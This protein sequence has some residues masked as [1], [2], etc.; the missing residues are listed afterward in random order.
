MMHSED[1]ET[2]K[3]GMVG[4][5][6]ALGAR[7]KNESVTLHNIIKTVEVMNAVPFRMVSL[8]I[9]YDNWF[10]TPI[11]ASIKVSLNTFTRL[12]TRSHYGK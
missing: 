4:V 11:M 8:H 3:R 1:L 9:C 5:V 12:R 10:V 2:Q 7:D 6:W